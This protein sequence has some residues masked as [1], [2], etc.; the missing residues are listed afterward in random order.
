MSFLNSHVNGFLDMGCHI[1][2]GAMDVNNL[3]AS[4][5]SNSNLRFQNTET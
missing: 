1:L 4:S 3:K 2:G 5:T